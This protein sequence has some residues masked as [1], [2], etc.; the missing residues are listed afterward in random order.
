[1]L[2]TLLNLYRSSSNNIKVAILKKSRFEKRLAIG[3]RLKLCLEEIKKTKEK[4]LKKCF[5]QISK[6]LQPALN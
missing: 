4:N 6:D 5:T 2:G 3:G 1:M